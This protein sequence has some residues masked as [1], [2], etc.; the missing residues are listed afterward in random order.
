MSKFQILFADAV[1][2]KEGELTFEVKLSSSVPAPR[3]IPD[4]D[5]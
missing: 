5:E 2:I 1:G 3:I 4:S